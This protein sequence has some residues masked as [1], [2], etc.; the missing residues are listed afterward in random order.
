MK[1]SILT[2]LITVLFSAAAYSTTDLEK[3][4][5][6]YQG[7]KYYAVSQRK[8]MCRK[9]WALKVDD[10][11]V[12]PYK[13]LTIDYKYGG[14]GN[15]FIIARTKG[16][17]KLE[18]YSGTRSWIGASTGPRLE[19]EWDWFYNEFVVIG[20]DDYR[21]SAPF[22]NLIA[23]PPY[24]VYELN[25][26]TL[27]LSEY[28]RQK[29]QR[30]FYPAEKYGK[31]TFATSFLYIE[32]PE[33]D[34][35]DGG[36][37]INTNA[38]DVFPDYKILPPWHGTGIRAVRRNDKECKR[39]L[40][41]P[42]G[43]VIL[44]FE[45]DKIKE[46]YELTPN[47][48]NKLIYA[49]KD[50][51]EGVFLPKQS[52]ESNGHFISPF[53]HEEIIYSLFWNGIC[54]AVIPDQTGNT[55]KQKLVILNDDPEKE[56]ETILS[57]T[58]RIKLILSSNV[59]KTIPQNPDI[60]W[61]LAQKDDEVFLYRLTKN[62]REPE[63]ILKVA[64]NIEKPFY[65]NGSNYCIV[66]NKKDDSYNLVLLG[67]SPEENKVLIS[68]NVSPHILTSSDTANSNLVILY[69]NHPKWSFYILT[70][71]SKEPKLLSKGKY[72]I[73]DYRCKENNYYIYDYDSH[74]YFKLNPLGDDEE[75][76]KQEWDTLPK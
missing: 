8:F 39:G 15:Y 5:F 20:V 38:E 70:N 60:H 73:M 9:K 59:S 72:Y 63:L 6:D 26:G 22:E 48:D 44:D 32:E 58:N 16:K 1:L 52:E 14:G 34:E 55:Y 76:T 36:H 10:K 19:R 51:K 27:N 61:F 7:K 45:Y 18:Y 46:V 43:E 49:F 25:E 17:K 3:Y 68:E 35:I 64:G 42:D 62:H 66:E 47:L 71:Q 11:I 53:K 57:G 50:G 29:L 23:S 74:K 65:W 21:E 12:T 24:S 54:Y 30:Y 4:L 75:I 13:Y 33:E 69:Y 56:D 28:Y 40:L 37:L 41:S 67:D 2:F 31:P